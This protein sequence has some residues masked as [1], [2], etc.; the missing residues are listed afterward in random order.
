MNKKVIILI[1][2]IVI[3]GTG[4]TYNLLNNNI[5]HSTATSG[6]VINKGVEPNSITLRTFAENTNST[7]EVKIIIKDENT[8][9]L[10][11]KERYYF[12]TYY[13]KNNEAPVLGQIQIND[14]F[15]KIYK[16]KLNK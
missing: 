10:I 15:G 14:E 6:I 13:W 3:I 5:N 2:L 1:V 11:E 9:N 8:W 4:F 7:E 12:V 16:G